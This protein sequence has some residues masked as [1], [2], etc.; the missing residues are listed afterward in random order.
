MGRSRRSDRDARPVPTLWRQCR[1]GHAPGDSVRRAL[2]P[3]RQVGASVNS[4]PAV[5]T[6]SERLSQ[7]RR[8]SRS[9]QSVIRARTSSGTSMP[10]SSRITRMSS[11]W[12]ST[13]PSAGRRWDVSERKKERSC[14]SGRVGD[15]RDVVRAQDEGTEG[16]GAPLAGADGDRLG[17]PCCGRLVLAGDEQN[18][19]DAVLRIKVGDVVGPTGGLV[20]ILL[21]LSLDDQEVA[22]AGGRVQ[23]QT[24][25]DPSLQRFDLGEDELTMWRTV[26]KARRAGWAYADSSLVGVVEGSV[27]FLLS[28]RVPGHA[29]ADAHQPSFAFCASTTAAES[30][31]S[32]GRDSA[33]AL[34]STEK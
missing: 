32:L 33:M 7:V 5:V 28:A 24:G 16:E 2:L 23:P 25:V 19:R 6:V 17:G 12:P 10:R 21:A 34:P 22:L 15:G 29:R 8:V 9:V 18:G 11:A 13:R 4:S 26:E 27:C 14:R 30:F 3:G 20:R 31:V 1:A